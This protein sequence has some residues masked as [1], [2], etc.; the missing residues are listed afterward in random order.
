MG[1]PAGAP[2]LQA[3]VSEVRRAV[4]DLL[5]LVEDGR[6]RTTELGALLGLLAALDTGHAA[7]VALT[8]RVDADDLAARD[9][10]LSLEGLLALSSRLTFGDRRTLTNTA[11]VL[12]DLPH[13]RRAFHAGAIG[14]AEVRAVVS[15]VRGL[16]AAARQHLDAGFADL[17]RFRQLDPDQVLDAVRDAVGRLRPDTAR[18][19]ATRTIEHR[20]L[21]L[22]PALDDALTGYFELDAQAGATFLAGLEAAMPPPSAGPRD[23]TRDAVGEADLDAVDDLGADD[24]PGAAADGQVRRADGRDAAGWLGRRSRARQRADAL[25]RLAELS[26]GGVTAGGRPRRARPRVEVV[27]DIRTLVGDDDTA[28]SA[29]LLWATAGSP[30]ILT[31]AAARRLAE[32]AD[33]RFLLTDG[34]EVLGV[35]APTPAIPAA[36]RTAVRARDQGCRFPGCSV[37]VHWTDLHHVTAREQG[38][39]TTVDNLVAVCRRHHVAVTE[40]RWRLSMDTQAAV[41]VRRGRRTAMSDPPARRDLLDATANAPPA[42]RT[43]LAT[44][45][46][47]P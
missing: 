18:D 14:W 20:F 39:P 43:D 40:G 3:A 27:A 6:V 26:L 47:V 28:R 46:C 15:E 22:Q 36:V 8:E 32:D 4:G 1:A 44:G 9:T 21:H 11:V 19:T 29:R 34:G 42:N 12:R 38:G 24:G 37:P 30:P 13:V 31:P 10:G 35:T 7:A 33:L 23:V 2:S 17:D 16:D 41:T 5:A 25:V 45:G